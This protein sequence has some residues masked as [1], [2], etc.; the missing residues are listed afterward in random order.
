MPEAVIVAATRAPIGRALKGSLAELRPDDLSAQ[1][2]EAVL[3]QVPPD[4]LAT[5]W[6]I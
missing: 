2:V 4:C 5:S 1:L 3:G 6:T